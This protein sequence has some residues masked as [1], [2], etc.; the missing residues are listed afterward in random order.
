MSSAF[1]FPLP[2]PHLLALPTEPWWGAESRRR[3]AENI[4]V[5]LPGPHSVPQKTAKSLAQVC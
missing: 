1:H 2:P 3:L 5:D 4:Y